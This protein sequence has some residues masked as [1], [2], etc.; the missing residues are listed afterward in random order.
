SMPGGTGGTGGIGTGSTTSTTSTYSRN[1]SHST[2]NTQSSSPSLIEDQYKAAN[3]LLMAINI[4]LE[5]VELGVDST[6]IKQE[7]IQ[8]DI[9][10]LSRIADQL[11]GMVAN[12]S[13]ANR[14]LWRITL[15]TFNHSITYSKVKKLT[16][17]VK[18]LR[19]SMDMYL[20]RTYKK[21]IEDE[22]R[23]K[24]FSRRKDT[25]NSALSNLMKENDL[26]KDSNQTIDEMTDTG[27]S[28][29]YALAGQNSRLKSVHKKIYDIANT[30]GLSRN[31]INR[32]KR[33]QQQDKIF[34]YSGMVIVLIFLYIMY[35][36]FR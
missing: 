20:Q 30:L 18:S 23:S 1:T 22:E 14:D 29:I 35:Y 26:L 10:Q 24:L 32:I 28:I 19:K 7:K 25:Q 15:L 8:A 16:E 13:P 31:V 12:E 17:E 27:N 6:V 36:Y 21:Q 3:K 5:R 9:N 33:R 11:D 34:V 2:S 4:D